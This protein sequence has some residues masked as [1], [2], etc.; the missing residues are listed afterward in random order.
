MN[1]KTEL[2]KA[3]IEGTEGA[4]KLAAPSARIAEEVLGPA[5]KTF[6]TAQ[7]NGAVAL[8]RGA[9]GDWVSFT[10]ARPIFNA[11]TTAAE[12]FAA[13][14]KSI[15]FDATP[16]TKYFPTLQ[17]TIHTDVAVI[18]GGTGGIAAARNV[19][20]QGLDTVLIEGHRIGASTSANMTMI[21][22]VPDLE[23]KPIM[24]IHGSKQFG[25]YV[26]QMKAAHAQVIEDARRLGADFVPTDSQKISY[27]RDSQPLKHEFDLL[28]PY[29]KDIEY[30]TGPEA[31]ARWE[32]AQTAVVLHGEG[33]VDPRK[34]TTGLAREANFPIFEDSPVLT[35]KPPEGGRPFELRTPNGRI[36]ANQVVF[37][38]N[39]PAPMF[40]HLRDFTVPVQC[41]ASA[42]RTCTKVVGNVFDDA[43]PAFSY[44]RKLSDDKL[45]FGGAARFTTA[46]DQAVASSPVLQET[47]EKLFPGAKMERSWT[48]TIYSTAG[49]GMPIL[50]RHPEQP[51][52]WNI[53]GLGGIGMVNSEL[54]GRALGEILK[55]GRTE[56][57][58]SAAR[59]RNISEMAADSPYKVGH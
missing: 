57:L 9:S 17:G 4:S 12:E 10:H 20:A 37:A 38:T 40:G 42:A 25:E 52:L 33:G 3:L 54:T 27:M 34:L 14:S 28:K 6:N 24:D 30:L 58:F 5:A 2:T 59:L 39:G 19:A 23:F 47:L 1:W 50:E 44:F 45:M 13:Q 26:A 21:T 11:E 18:G 35:F 41:F 46:G 49:D 16:A 15:F 36:L 31:Q 7:R 55:G 8:S 22:R 48:G 53:T 32:R 56:N 43:D 51:R 29:D